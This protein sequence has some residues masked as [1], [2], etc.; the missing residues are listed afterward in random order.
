MEKLKKQWNRAT[1]YLVIGS[2]FWFIE[3][4]VFL[5]IDGWHIHPIKISE[6]VCDT[7]VQLLYLVGLFNYFWVVS[8]VIS[9]VLRENSNS[10]T[11]GE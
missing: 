9:A 3:T 4:I 1:N 10:K 11:L 2:I 6:L 5:C 7:L 8:E